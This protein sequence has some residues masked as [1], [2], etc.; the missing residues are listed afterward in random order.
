L[1]VHNIR[2]L[3]RKEKTERDKDVDEYLLLALRADKQQ[4]IRLKAHFKKKKTRSTQQIHMLQ[5]KL[6]QFQ[7]VLRE[8]EARGVAQVDQPR[9][10]Q[11]KVLRRV[12]VGLK[13]VNILTLH[14]L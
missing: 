2:E 3:I 14:I 5:Q 11:M 4:R 8:L 9:E 1:E 6:D 10:P 13:C 7:K 12:E